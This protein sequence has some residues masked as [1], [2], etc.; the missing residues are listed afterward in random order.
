MGGLL[1]VCFGA[2]PPSGELNERSPLLGDDGVAHDDLAPGPS[3]LKAEEKLQRVVRKACES[4]IDIST[5]TSRIIVPPEEEL[6]VPDPV[7]IHVAP[8][9]PSPIVDTDLIVDVVEILPD[10]DEAV[11]IRRAMDKLLGALGEFHVRYTG[12]VVVQWN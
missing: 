10:S 7:L 11:N 5:T 6:P 8:N 4:F 2:R 9:A 1:S 12:D 3:Y